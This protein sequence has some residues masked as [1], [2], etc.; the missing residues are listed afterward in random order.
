[1]HIELDRVVRFTLLAAALWSIFASGKILLTPVTITSQSAIVLQP[2]TGNAVEEE[3]ATT[4]E[5]QSWFKTQ[6]WWGVLVL[7]LFGA[8]YAG[9]AVLYAQDRRAFAAVLSLAAIALTI[10]AGLSIG[11]LYVPAGVLTLI[12]WILLAI[13][14]LP[15]LRQA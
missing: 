6:G 8:L 11:L 10:L 9:A 13:A 7:S 15:S 2:S 3:T 14:S 4:E 5:Q 1:M 12:A